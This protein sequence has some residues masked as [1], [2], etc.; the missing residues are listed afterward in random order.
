M[1]E[2]RRGAYRHREDGTLCHFLF[3]AGNERG[4]QIVT[5]VPIEEEQLQ[6][7]WM[8]RTEFEEK[9]VYFA[10][11]VAVERHAADPGKF[12]DLVRAILGN[13]GVTC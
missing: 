12:F 8:A 1:E 13:E 7:R 6:F 10:E 2:I 9:F 4:E 3:C 5:F 11:G